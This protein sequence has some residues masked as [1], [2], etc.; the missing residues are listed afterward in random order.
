MRNFEWRG[1]DPFSVIGTGEITLDYS[2]QFGD[3]HFREGCEYQKELKSLVHATK[4]ICSLGN[5]LMM[6]RSWS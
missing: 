1:S 3:Q 6:G 2:A 5:S 4:L